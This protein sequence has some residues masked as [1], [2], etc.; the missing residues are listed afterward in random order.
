MSGPA[1]LY[2]REVERLYRLQHGTV[3]RLIRSGV[4]RAVRRGRRSLLRAADVHGYFAGV[5]HAP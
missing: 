1:L 5:T 2:A 4:L 3:R